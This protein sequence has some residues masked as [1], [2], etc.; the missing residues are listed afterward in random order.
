VAPPPSQ[1]KLERYKMDKMD[2][3]FPSERP[4][5]VLAPLGSFDREPYT[6][7]PAVEIRNLTFSYVPGKMAPIFTNLS[8][9]IKKGSRCLL[10]GSN[11]AGK[12]T[13]LRVLSGMH[14]V[15]ESEVLVFGK[16]AFH[17]TFFSNQNVS[18]LGEAWSRSVAYVGN[19]VPYSA[20]I[21]VA[22]MIRNRQG[23]EARR[24]EYLISLLDVDT[25]WRMHEVSDG[26]RKRVMILLKMLRPFSLLLLDE[27]TTHLDVISRLDFLNFLKE[28]SE[29]R[30]VTIVYATHIFD[31]M[32]D[33]ASDLIH[34]SHGKVIKQGPKSD[35]SA[36]EDYKSRG[37]SAPLLRLVT[38]W[39]RAEREEEKKALEAKS[40]Q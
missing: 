21:T 1:D 19:G 20:D 15:P 25:T 28:E 12:S 26:Q 6:S 5:A 18:F 14:M 16:S 40:K 29:C 38:H 22:D 9:S 13:L 36:L 27:V 31:G 23:V 3:L 35:F 33:W 8:V 11:G 39:L 30:G 37:L 24:C 7:H 2:D 4:E 32:E 17:D 34:L 10:I